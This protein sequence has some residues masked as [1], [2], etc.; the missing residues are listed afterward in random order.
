VLLT[1]R[2]K[3]LA[4]LTNNSLIG[5]AASYF[6]SIYLANKF[7]AEKFGLYSYILVVSS[8]SVIFINWAS[9]QTAPSYFSE[10]KS[11]SEIFNI[12]LTARIL[13]SLLVTIFLL[14]WNQIDLFVFI[15]VVII[16]VSAFNLSF[17][18]EISAKNTLYSFVYMIERLFYVFLV[19]TLFFFGLEDLKYVLGAYLI[20]TILSLVVQYLFL[21]QESLFAYKWPSLSELSMYFKRNL[22]FVIISFSAFVYGG[23]S[24]LFIGDKLGMSALGVFSTGMQITVLATIFQAQVERIW[25]VP[26]YVSFSE[27]DKA[28][29][30]TNIWSF[31]KL[32]TFPSFLIAIVF[33]LF[34]NQ[35]VEILF[36]KEYK[37]LGSVLP[38]ISLFFV[39]INLTSLFA[40][41]WFALKKSKEYLII[42]GIVSL[43]LVGILY[44]L[45]L[46]ATLAEYLIS[47]LLCQVGLI[48]Y[49]SMRIYYE[50]EH[51]VSIDK[52][53]K[54]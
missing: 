8:I 30:K 48:I 37:I 2:F 20:V 15:A 36:S 33:A 29:I 46:S 14:F 43:I 50:V 26:L 5:S 10:G 44:I 22:S 11:K 18:F 31:I 54:I 17:L 16:N 25:R 35:I 45:P 53:H 28:K 52:N 7:G 41:C 49:S 47:I 38:V 6:L 32:S 39:T 42:S 51:F 27:C 19:I 3:Q 23:I 40:I 21:E 24:R 12:V 9:D 1:E 34:S 4:L 13:I